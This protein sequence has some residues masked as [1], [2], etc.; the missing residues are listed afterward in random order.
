MVNVHPIAHLGGEHSQLL[1]R[2]YRGANCWSLPPGT[3]F[4]PREQSSTLLG[5]SPWGI[6]FAP[7]GKIKTCHRVLTKHHLQHFCIYYLFVKIVFCHF[8]LFQRYTDYSSLYYCKVFENN[9]NK[10]CKCYL[11]KGKC[12]CKQPYHPRIL[13]LPNC[14]ESISTLVCT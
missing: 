4:I 12:T 7:R 2:M 13:L 1:R 10:F 5:N 14:P 6:K 8:Y 9:E 3:N 11:F